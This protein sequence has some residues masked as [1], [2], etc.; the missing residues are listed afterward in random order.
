VSL[1][2]KRERLEAMVRDVEARRGHVLARLAELDAPGTD[3]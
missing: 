3:R 1:R 2:E